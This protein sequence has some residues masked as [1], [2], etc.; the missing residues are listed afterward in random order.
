MNYWSP[1]SQK[2]SALAPIS[3]HRSPFRPSPSLPLF[4]SNLTIHSHNP[5]PAAHINHQRIASLPFRTPK[6][7]GLK[8]MIPTGKAVLRGSEPLQNVSRRNAV[9]NPS[10][11]VLSLYAHSLRGHKGQKDRL[12]QDIYMQLPHFQGRQDSYLLSLS[13][14]HG[15]YG[16]LV[17]GAVCEMLPVV[18]GDVKNLSDVDLQREAQ[19]L[20]HSAVLRIHKSVLQSLSFNPGLSGCTLLTALIHSHTLVLSHVG[21]SRAL[22][23]QT[24]PGAS[25]TGFWVYQQL[26]TDHTPDLPLERARIESKKGLVKPRRDSTG[27]YSGP[28]RVWVQ[29]ENLPGLAMSRSIG[30]SVA[31]AVGVSEVPQ[32]IVHRLEAR[33]KAL[34]L[35]SDGLWN[36][37]SNSE[38]TMIVQRQWSTCENC[39]LELVKVAENRWNKLSSSA[40]DITVMVVTL[41]F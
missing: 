12:N 3:A 13:D 32:V 2:S 7:R 33:D 34:I 11:G 18:L 29:G 20:F 22:L 15:Q 19:G 5:F 21:D 6:I 4:P 26:T 37:L 35:A 31:H 9:M 41:S 25:E 1:V 8:Q 30:D 36:V 24:A 27:A 10:L 28:A 16:H 38:V 17:A 14:G 40:D 23:V 39:C